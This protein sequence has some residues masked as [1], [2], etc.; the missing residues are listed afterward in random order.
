MKEEGK[1]KKK[2][3]SILKDILVE[4]RDSVLFEAVWM[5]LSFIPRVIMGIF[6]N[7]I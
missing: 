6:R 5:V 7:L 2:N 4:I 1:S 3:H